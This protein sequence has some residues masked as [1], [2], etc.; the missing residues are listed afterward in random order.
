MIL[1]DNLFQLRAKFMSQAP[2]PVECFT[3][4]PIGSDVLFWPLLRF[5]Q[6]HNDG[7]GSTSITNHA[8]APSPQH[9]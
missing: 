8:I 3:D 1:S 6:Q 5:L 2:L 4:L 9:A 7:F